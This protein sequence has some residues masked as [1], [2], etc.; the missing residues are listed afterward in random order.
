MGICS[1]RHLLAHINGIFGH[2][3][4]PSRH[5]DQPDIVRLRTRAISMSQCYCTFI[6][7]R[8]LGTV[9]GE[10]RKVEKNMKMIDERCLTM[11]DESVGFFRLRD[12]AESL[13]C[14]AFLSI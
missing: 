10:L 4:F 1:P 13:C 3:L 5:I 12:A 11:I 2:G 6:F 7:F 8:M 14:K 9:P